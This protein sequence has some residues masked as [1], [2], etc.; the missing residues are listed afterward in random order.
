MDCWDAPKLSS[1]KVEVQWGAR[2]VWCS[3]NGETVGNSDLWWRDAHAPAANMTGVA[4]KNWRAEGKEMEKEHCY[5]PDD[6][7]DSTVFKVEG[8]GVKC[9]DA[10]K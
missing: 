6:A 1:E 5:V 3:V 2:H 4:A 10:G 8:G 9:A 7:F